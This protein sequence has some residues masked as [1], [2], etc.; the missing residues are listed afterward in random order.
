MVSTLWKFADLLFGSDSVGP[1][2]A[3]RGPLSLPLTAMGLAA[4]LSMA[5]GG[6]VVAASPL[7]GKI[8]TDNE[9]T[10]R[11]VPL[12]RD[13]PIGNAKLGV[14]VQSLDTREI[15]L[16]IGGEETLTPASNFKLF[17]TAAGLVLL[18]ADYTWN[19]DIATSGTIDDAGVLHGD[20]YLIGHGDPTLGGRFNPD[21]TTD[22]TW[23]MREWA[24]KIKE[25]GITRIDGDVIGDDNFFGDDYFGVA[26]YPDERAEWYCAEV[27]ALS[28]NDGCV[29]IVWK[30][31]R[32]K[33]QPAEFALNPPTEYC[34]ILNRVQTVETSVKEWDITYTRPE[35]SNAIEAKGKIPAREKKYDYAAIHNPTLFTTT[36][37]METL[38]REGIDV[39]GVAKDIDDIPG[40][41]GGGAN[42]LFSH[43]SPPLSK[44]IEVINRNSQNLYAELLL[45]TLGKVKGDGGKFGDGCRVVENFL[46]GRGLLRT[47]YCCVDGS[48]LSYL[49]R[50]SAR[51][52]VDLL[53]FMYWA[54]ESSTYMDSLP[55]G[56]ARGSLKTRFQ[57]SETAKR[58]A[59][60]IYAKTG[61]IGG[62]HSVSGYIKGK[63]DVA[64]SIVLNDFECPD[65]QARNLVDRIA[66]EIATWNEV[67][68]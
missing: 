29:D 35:T 7:D 22:L 53:R 31:A 13:V 6:V 63:P 24:A 1:A 32:K 65:T 23:Q 45:R 21:D 39:T 19:T 48:G 60:R 37:F 58:V 51:Q 4:I 67:T 30:G 38:R 25:K 33:G 15:L 44:I 10:S 43:T 18:G 16:D 57:D 68:Q 61:W 26:W 59:S 9:L 52:L 14:F 17:T 46:S 12:I 55:Q 47:G 62:V 20:L 41:S 64:F 54:K 40:A 56:G 28:F 66:V 8:K 27:A 2:L 11:V 5:F 50:T 49:N 36:V 3:G 42:V 34:T